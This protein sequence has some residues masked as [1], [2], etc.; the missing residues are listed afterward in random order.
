MKSIKIT[1]WIS[2]CIIAALVFFSG[3]NYLTREEVKEACHHLGFPDYFRIELAI[4]KFLAAF[5]LL[6]PVRSI[7]KEWAYF[8]C[9]II[10][11]SAPIAHLASDDPALQSFGSIGYLVILI[12]SYVSYHRYFLARNIR[13]LIF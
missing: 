1:Y 13:E 2:T 9:I 10:F 4:A 6:I 3:Y 7:L 8:G 5:A 11:V 12:I